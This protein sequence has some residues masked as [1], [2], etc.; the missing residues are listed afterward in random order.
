MALASLL[1]P[2]R[3]VSN[4]I[5]FN[6][7]PKSPKPLYYKP[8]ARRNKIMVILFS[9]CLPVKGLLSCAE[10][11]HARGDCKLQQ[12]TSTPLMKG[13]GY[14]LQG[15]FLREKMASSAYVGVV[16]LTKIHGIS[17]PYPIGNE[18]PTSR[19]PCSSL[20]VYLSSILKAIS[21]F[22]FSTTQ[23]CNVNIIHAL[24]QDAQPKKKVRY[25][26]CR[27]IVSV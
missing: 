14:V 4:F 5:L 13:R 17:E 20:P 12:W 11:S 19:C 24:M 2:P 21:S 27:I 25:F 7:T 8:K 23:T 15:C 10:P 16:K 3:S 18:W 9:L 1:Y 22:S 6:G 26:R